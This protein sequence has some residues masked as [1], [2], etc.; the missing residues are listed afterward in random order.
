M[1]KRTASFLLA[2]ALLVQLL[3]VS[4]L[5]TEVTGE[6]VSGTEEAAAAAAGENFCGGPDG[7]GENATWS[8]DA[9]S[10]TLTISGS[11]EV[12]NCDDWKSLGSINTVEIGEG[13]TSVG[14][15]QKCTPSHR[16]CLRILPV[17]TM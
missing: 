12:G 1:K 10:G 14:A 11:G 17:P 2:L 9:A 13:I 15:I 6:T 16:S 4:A 5:A 7:T 3:P 8:F